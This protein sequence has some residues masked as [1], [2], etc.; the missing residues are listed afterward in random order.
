M[1]HTGNIVLRDGKIYYEKNKDK[2]L[3]RN[4]KY[5][6]ENKEKLREKRKEKYQ[7]NIEKYREESKIRN[8]KVT[9]ETKKIYNQ[10]Y[11]KKHK[12]KIINHLN[13]KIECDI[14]NKKITRSYL[15][16]HRKNKHPE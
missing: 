13:E 1:E 15:S 10:E 9:K 2:I 7:N 16:V 4:R 11:Y 5:R 12:E 14:C 3:E 6:E 8:R